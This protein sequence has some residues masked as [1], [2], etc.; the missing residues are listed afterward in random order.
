ML[1]VRACERAGIRTAVIVAEQ[2]DPASTDPA[3][4]DWVPEADCVVSTGNPRSSCRPGCPSVVLGGETLLDGRS[5]RDAGRSGCRT[6]WAP[7]NQMGQLDLTAAT[8]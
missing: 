1:T 3:L 6:T 7:P 2:T 8:W 4:T 5:A